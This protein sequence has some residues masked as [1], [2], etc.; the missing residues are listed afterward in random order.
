M[1]DKIFKLSDFYFNLPEAKIAKYPLEKREESKLFI[2]ERDKKKFIHTKF[3]NIEDYLSLNDLLVFNN[4]KVVHARIF[5]KRLTGAK[6]EIV[7]A[8]KISEKLYL[9]ISN[10][11]KKLKEQEE[12][13]SIVDEKI[14][15]KVMERSGDYLKISSNCELTEEVLNRIGEIPLPPYLKRKSELLDENRYQT[16]FAKEPGAAASPTAGLHFTNEI[17]T[18]LENKGIEIVYLTLYVSWGT[19]QPVRDED[20]S[21]HKMHVEKYHLSKEAAIKINKARNEKRRI[22]SVGTTSLRVLETT[23][24]ENENIPGTGETDIFIYPPRKIK[25]VN[26]LITNFHTPYSTLLMLVSSFC[27]YDLIMEAYNVAIKKGY[28]FFSYGDAMFIL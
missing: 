8:R 18:R 23:F 28:R 3:F 6:V 12:L 11:T 14:K 5:C 16:V 7:I 13:V 9:V 4:V 20:L 26:G 21:N 19:F 27:G 22:I 15:I 1:S 25:S 24:R 2:I 10:K 17:I